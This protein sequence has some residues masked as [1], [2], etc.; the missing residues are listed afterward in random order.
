MTSHTPHGALATP[1]RWAALVF[2][3]VV[4]ALTGRPAPGWAKS[5]S[6]ESIHVEATVRGDGSLAI[7]EE[8][9][10]V[11]NGN[12]RFAF[13]EIPLKT[14]ETLS[15]VSV[16][17]VSGVYRRAGGESPGTFTMLSQGSKTKITW[18][19][20]AVDER[21]TFH[22]S[23]IIGGVVKR[24]ADVAELYYKFIGGDRDRRIREL[25]VTVHPPAGMY[26]SDI[27][28]WAH[29]PLS[30][31][32]EIGADGKVHFNVS[33][34]PA[35]AFWEGRILYPTDRFMDVPASGGGPALTTILD[36]ERRWAEE[37]NRRRQAHI[38]R[39]R[40]AAIERQRKKEL[41]K[42]FMFVSL[43]AGAMGL[44]MW[45]RAFQRYGRPYRVKSHAVPGEIPSKHRPAM[46]SYLLYR[47]VAGPAIVA[48]LLNL[49]D[50]GYFTITE[51]EREKKGWFGRTR[52]EKDYRFDL[53][54]KRMADLDPFEMKL[55]EFMI[56]EAGDVTGFTMSGLKK[57][58][59]RKRTAFRKWFMEWMKEVKKLGKTMDFYE[60]YP[61][62]AMAVNGIAGALL[63]G[64]GILF[65]TLTDSPSG[66]AA[67][68]AGVTIAIL[69]VT[70]QRRT[71]EGKRLHVAWMAFRKH[72][73][74]VGKAM[75]PVRLDSTAW[76]RYMVAAIVFGMHKQLF[77]KL[78]LIG[79]DGRRMAPVWFYGGANPAGTFDDSLSSLASGLT[80]MVNTVSTTMSSASGTG[81]GASGGGGGGSGG[82]SVGAG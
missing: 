17:D 69:T 48:T 60:P 65:S 35:R 56:T 53:T 22:F 25:R 27:R 29:G 63:L 52:K 9:T 40:Q 31:T 3:I 76:E 80:S 37:A 46:L 81:G 5:Y 68:A 67:I 14:G 12:F 58:A 43:V 71:K 74:K 78:E 82:G 44:F 33:H 70:L 41:G 66:A 51:T 75:G 38:E 49:A 61:V 77:P 36:E 50:R 55:V 54:E 39:A 11:F 6:I 4:L 16:S 23:Y 18:Y 42:K 73:T 26:K 62:R 59:T 24:H 21:R 47:G 57:A 19:Y 7:E 1:C 2:V 15:D 45:Y 79:D 10:Y 28:A 20:R 64:M 8:I 13:R 30:G 34:L 72:L 32:V